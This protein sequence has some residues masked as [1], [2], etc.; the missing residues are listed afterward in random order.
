M[1]SQTTDRAHRNGIKERLLLNDEEEDIIDSENGRGRGICHPRVTNRAIHPV[2]E[3]A[4]RKAMSLR[5]KEGSA[6][7]NLW[8]IYE[9]RSRDSHPFRGDT[10]VRVAFCCDP[11]ICIGHFCGFRDN[12]RDTRPRNHTASS[13]QLKIRSQFSGSSSTESSS[14]SCE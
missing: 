9:R 1:N 6:Q 13:W 10:N 7:R 3:T 11:R 14:F 2:P 4:N 8:N 12:T 5:E